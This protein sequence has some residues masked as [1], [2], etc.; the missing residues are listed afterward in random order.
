ML[1]E[2]SLK[3]LQVLKARKIFVQIPEGLKT[4]ALEI[5]GFLESRGFEPVVS[6]EPCFGACDLRDH[7]AVKLGCDALLHIGHTD[8]AVKAELP[9][10]YDEWPSDFDPVT[11]MRRNFRQVQ[12]YENIGL[13]TVAQHLGSIDSMRRFLEGNG[14]HVLI[15][16]TLPLAA[17]QVLGCNYSNVKAVDN[18][19]D[20]FVFV[21]SGDFH[22]SEFS[23]AT[24]KPVFFINAETG[25]FSTL[26]YNRN[27]EELKRRLRIEKASNMH[28]FGIFV[29][30]KPGQMHMSTAE[31]LRVML[32]EKGKHALII[33]ADMLTPEKIMGMGIEVLVNTACPRIYDDQ[34]LF[35]MLILNPRDAEH[36]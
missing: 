36:L 33:S 3:E 13:A 29:S 12:K 14:K 7:D 9:V 21:G 20:C 22:T 4:K 26:Q 19:V 34:E 11:V 17:G 35:K 10:V 32:V 1:S 5:S 27:R 6:V 28:T 23:S 25:T 15:G 2:N 30:T 16:H 8:F 31:R 24:Q 18:K